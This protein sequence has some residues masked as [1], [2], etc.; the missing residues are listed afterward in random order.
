MSELPKLVLD[1]LLSNH[2]EDLKETINNNFDEIILFLS[3]YKEENR[4]ILDIEDKLKNN[5]LINFQDRIKFYFKKINNTEL[6]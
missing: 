4:N 6:D 3:K 5:I 2:S 1:E